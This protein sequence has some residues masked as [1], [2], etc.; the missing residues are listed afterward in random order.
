MKCS[1]CKWWA[2]QAERVSDDTNVRLCENPRI[3]HGYDF[4]HSAGEYLAIVE[5]DEGWG[6]ATTAAFGCVLHERAE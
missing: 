2:E 5:G 1:T 3:Y 4:D 6:I